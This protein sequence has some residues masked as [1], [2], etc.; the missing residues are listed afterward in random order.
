MTAAKLHS[1]S[2]QLQSHLPASSARALTLT[3]CRLY[4]TWLICEHC[5]RGSL[6]DIIANGQLSPADPAQRSIWVVLCLLDIALGLDY[7]HS[8]TIVSAVL[9]ACCARCD[10]CVQL[11]Q[12][13]CQ[14]SL[15]PLFLPACVSAPCVPSVR[16]TACS[17]P[18]P[19]AS[20][21]HPLCRFTV[22]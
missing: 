2:E 21:C 18:C 11:P 14:I 12:S 6:A 4:E 9:S 10:C 3:D 13:Q 22:T 15:L 1:S 8:S 7:L 20:L 17:L 19:A 5:D 16:L